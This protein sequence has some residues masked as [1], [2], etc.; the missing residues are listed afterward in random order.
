MN[1]APGSCTLEKSA[2]TALWLSCIS[3]AGRLDHP[4]HR[5]E[6]FLSYLETFP[7]GLHNRAAAERVEDLICAPDLANERA[8]L[9][10]RLR[11]LRDPYLP[12]V[13]ANTWSAPRRPSVSV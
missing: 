3:T 8:E 7:T 10:H 9:D 2:D 12:P 5:A 13:A 4:L 11:S 1:E 6:T